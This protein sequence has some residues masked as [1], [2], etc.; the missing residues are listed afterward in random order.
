VNPGNG[1]P[2]IRRALTDNR[3]RRAIEAEVRRN[4]AE[5]GSSIGHTLLGFAHL[6]AREYDKAIDSFLRAQGYSSMWHASQ[7]LAL[8]YWQ[9][10]D[11]P[12][13][14]EYYKA[15]TTLSE[16][17]IFLYNTGL[18]LVQTGNDREAVGYLERARVLNE[19]FTPVYPLLLDA[20]RRLG[21]SDRDQELGR[22]HSQA[23]TRAR[24][25]EHV[26]KAIQFHRDGKPDAAIAETK[27]ALQLAPRNAEALST[28]GDIYFHRGRLDEA[29]AEQRAALEAD[30]RFAEAHYRLALI[31]QSRADYAAARTHFEAYLQLEPWSPLSLRAREELSQLPR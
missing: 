20:Y 18:A 31:H 25:S 2:A 4:V 6:Q 5:T 23:V 12:R 14:I 26:R 22:A 11:L 15:L 21:R 19:G 1:V 17:P 30:P 10:G 24:A 27:A 13:A 7:G 8:A 3:R 29:L 28:L 16:D 9:Q